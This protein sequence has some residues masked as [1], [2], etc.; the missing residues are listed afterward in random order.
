MKTKTVFVGL[1]KSEYVKAELSDLKCRLCS[2]SFD[3]LNLIA[4]HLRDVHK[5][6]V[7]LQ[8]QLG[9]MPYLLKDKGWNCAVCSRTL[10]SLCSLNKHTITHFL[11]Y[12]CD[13]C[14]KSYISATGLAQHVKTKHV[15]ECNAFCKRCQKTFPS[16][17]ARIQHHKSEKKCMPHC[18]SKCPER[19]PKWDLK[20]RHLLEVH[21]I[22][23]KSHECPKCGIN[24]AVRRTFSDHFKKCH[25]HD[26]LICMYCGLKFATG[27]RLNRHLVKHDA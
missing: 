21:G 6:L 8:F 10:P 11:N 1:P 26:L 9:L 5:K 19:F 20:Q 24:F 22:A 25:S 4:E 23:K 17:E 18:C 2:Q 14:G 13:A 27:S 16:M 3:S 12:V 15:N 7:D